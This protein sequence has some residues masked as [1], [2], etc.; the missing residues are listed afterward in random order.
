MPRNRAET[1]I[2]DKREYPNPSE[3]PNIPVK[4]LNRAYSFVWTMEKWQI[5]QEA[6]KMDL[7]LEQSSPV[8]VLREKFFVP[9]LEEL[10]FDIKG[11][12][13]E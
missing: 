9:Y 7:R 1:K 13:K 12:E 2:K 11:P 3:F 10:G 8:E 4:G 6:A 5:L